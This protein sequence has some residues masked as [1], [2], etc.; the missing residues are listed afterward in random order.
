MKQKGR[1]IGDKGEPQ[2]GVTSQNH[3]SKMKTDFTLLRRKN[4]RPNSGIAIMKGYILVQLYV[5]V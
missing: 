4:Q 1:N 5:K 2:T 3:I